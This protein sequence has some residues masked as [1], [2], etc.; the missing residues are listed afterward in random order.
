MVFTKTNKNKSVKES[1]IRA[2]FYVL[3]ISVIMNLCFGLSYGIAIIFGSKMIVNGTI[4]I[5]DFIAFNSYIALFVN[6]VNFMPRMIGRLKRGQVSYKRIDDV[7]KLQRE[8]LSCD[9]IENKGIID[10]DIEIKN[11]NFSYKGFIDKVLNN[12][13]ITIKKGQTIGIIGKV[14]SGKSTL[15][16]LLVKL[17]D[18]PRG[19][20]LI[21]GVDINDID[22]SLLRENFCYITQDNFLFSTTIKQNVNLFRDNYDDK[23]IEDS[24]KSSMIYDEVMSLENGIETVIGERGID[25]SGGQKQRVVISRAFLAKSNFVIFDDTFSALDNKTEQKLLKNIKKLT[26]GKTCIII[27]NRISDIKHA[28]KIMVMEN[29]QIV[30]SG[31]HKDLM[32]KK[33]KYYQFY[34]EQAIRKDTSLLS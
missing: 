7:L 26:D 15:M 3:L 13:N 10:G 6:P 12:I 28:D 29:G 17:Y 23:N 25:L 27:S 31:T 24:L 1:N 5:G 20:I 32:Q 21:G 22:T 16:N 2:D 33:D 18:V 11:L 19:S 30:E 9:I 8:I 4:T 14:G 34:R